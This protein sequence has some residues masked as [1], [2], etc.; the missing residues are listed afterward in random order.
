LKKDIL[1]K[2]Q[3]M[4]GSFKILRAGG[5]NVF[6]HWTFLLLAGWLVLVNIRSGSGIPQV[7]WSIIFILAALSCVLLHE[8]GHAIAAAWFGINARNIVL[9]PIGGIASIEKFPG[10]PRQELAISLAGPLV[11]LA[12]A[13]LLWLMVS[14][15]VSFWAEPD[16]IVPGGGFLYLLR[17]ANLGLAFF[18]LIP[19]FP[20]DGGRILRALL[21]FK[22]NYVR[23]TTVAAVIGKVVAALFIAAGILL[24][25]PVAAI[26]GIFIILS[27]DAEEYYLRLRSLVQ[28]VKLGEAL[29]YDFTSLQAEMT[30]QEAANILV[31]NHSKYFVLMD[32]AV[33]VGSIN[34][35]EIVKAIA[36]MRYHQPLKSLVKEDLDTLDGS[37]E[38]QEVLEKLA[39]DEGRI[40]PVMDQGKFAGIASFDHIIEYL[41]LHKAGSKDFVRLKSMAGLMH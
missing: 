25:N 29:M 32:G 14:P 36:E 19:A 27:A 7:I 10:N 17:M 34:R 33:P 3:V 13:L 26:I 39:K 35:L 16:D 9:L 12:I 23:A 38:V 41:L 31:N 24:M 2:N 15:H 21:A 8:A 11:N 1:N 20:M 37:E 6:I 4:R 18:N 22:L 30:V 40:Y 5:I 28:G